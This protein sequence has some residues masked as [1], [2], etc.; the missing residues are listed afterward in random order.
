LPFGAR[1]AIVS[2]IGILLYYLVLVAFQYF[3]NTN[4]PDA[5]NNSIKTSAQQV[6]NA[7]TLGADL[8]P[9]S[10]SATRWST[11]SSS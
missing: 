11:G 5:F 4:A 1:L 9:R 8:R 2:L 6:A 3:S 10:P 7:L